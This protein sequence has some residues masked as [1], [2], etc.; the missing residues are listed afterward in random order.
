MEI[1]FVIMARG[2]LLARESHNDEQ[3]GDHD[4][5][6]NRDLAGEESHVSCSTLIQQITPKEKS[7][8]GTTQMAVSV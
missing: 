5:Y 3:D 4:R 7:D 8:Y 6:D 1:P 2:E